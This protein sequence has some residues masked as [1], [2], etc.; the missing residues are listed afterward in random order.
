MRSLIPY[1]PTS[2]FNQ[3]GI[4]LIGYSTVDLQDNGSTN[5]V[6]VRRSSDDT[7]SDFTVAEVND[8]TLL[9]WVNTDVDIYTSDFTSGS[10]DFNTTS[11][12]TINAPISIAGVDDSLRLTCD[13]ATG[14][15]NAIKFSVFNGDGSDVDISF[16]YYVPSSNAVVDGMQIWIPGSTGEIIGSTL[17]AWSSASGTITNTGGAS[18]F[19]S[20]RDGSSLNFGGASGDVIYVK[21][22]VVT[23]TNANGHVTTLYNTGSQAS[24]NLINTTASEQPLIV[25]TGTLVTS[26]TETSIN[27]SSDLRRLIS[28]STISFNSDK[29]I[30]IDFETGSDIS[31]RQILI[32]LEEDST[33]TFGITISGTNL[34]VEAINDSNTIS[35][36]YNSV[37]ST[38]TRYKFTIVIENNDITLYVNGSEVV[39]DSTSGGFLG[40][41]SGDYIGIGGYEASSS[42]P[43]LGKVTTFLAYDGNL[44][45]NHATGFNNAY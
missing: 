39:E 13:A 34:Y 45:Q 3:F 44:G 4:P 12:A 28:G 43:F 42:H 26:G 25:N 20:A 22:I 23:Q 24:S 5:S 31:T 35:R 15:H 29:T 33:D 18:L 2:F 10:S 19:M 7:E 17:D 36:R 38:S 8:G 27:Y 1:L 14:G 6:T 40:F 41:I 11:N 9:S 16:D 37:L 32:A 21:N 30:D